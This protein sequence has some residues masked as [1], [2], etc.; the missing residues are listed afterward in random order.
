[1]KLNTDA[2]TIRYFFLGN[3]ALPYRATKRDWYVG[4]DYWLARYA[5]RIIL[6]QDNTER[7]LS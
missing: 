4:H 1:M 3:L 6:F 5:S 2:A 7:V